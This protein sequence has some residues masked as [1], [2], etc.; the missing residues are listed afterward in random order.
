M[1]LTAKV[2]II[3]LTVKLMSSASVLDLFGLGVSSSDCM[4]PPS[5][6]CSEIPNSDNGQQEHM[7]A[8]VL[9]RAVNGYLE[10][11]PC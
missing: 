2:N 11:I 1:K 4:R 7:G 10:H 9:L 8:H 3:T 5:W 6:P